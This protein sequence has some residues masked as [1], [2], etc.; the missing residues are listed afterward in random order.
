MHK[1]LLW[2]ILALFLVACS[3]EAQTAVNGKPNVVA[4]TGQIADA[5]DQRRG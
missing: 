3:N 1:Q 5:V 2:L 4:T